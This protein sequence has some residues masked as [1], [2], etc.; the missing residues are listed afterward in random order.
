MAVGTGAGSS[1]VG[2]GAGSSVVGTG[3]GSSVVGTG[4]GPSAIGSEVGSGSAEGAADPHAEIIDI[5][6]ISKIMAQNC[7]LLSLSNMR[8]LMNMAFSDYGIRIYFCKETRFKNP[9]YIIFLS[10]GIFSLS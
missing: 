9:T 10:I 5:V 7:T 2:V 4:A 3:T 8:N 1:I 6:K